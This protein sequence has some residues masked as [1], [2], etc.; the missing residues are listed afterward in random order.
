MEGICT[1]FLLSESPERLALANRRTHRY[2][3]KLCHQTEGAAAVS[4][5]GNIPNK[6][7]LAPSPSPAPAGQRLGQRGACVSEG[8]LASRPSEGRRTV[9]GC[10][11]TPAIWCRPSLSIFRVRRSR[12]MDHGCIDRPGQVQYGTHH[13]QRVWHKNTFPN[14]IALHKLSKLKLSA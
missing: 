5:A 3:C 6:N 1:L 14:P 9:A 7:C 13:H 10:A 4:C 12:H 2:L 8:T 11:A